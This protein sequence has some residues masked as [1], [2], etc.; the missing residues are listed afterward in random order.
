M[1]RL[2]ILLLLSSSAWAVDVPVDAN[3]DPNAASYMLYSRAE[4]NP[5]WG[6]PVSVPSFPAV[7]PGI[8][9]V[10]VTLIKA[11]SVNAA[12]T[13]WCRDDAG[14]FY[15]ADSRPLTMNRVSIP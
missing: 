8:P 14:V 6:N 11:C 13:E 3:G 12:G 7:Y 1:I 10:G 5:V 4:G 9:D 15:D 2:L